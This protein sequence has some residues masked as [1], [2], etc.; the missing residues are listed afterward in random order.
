[1]K[2]AKHIPTKKILKVVELAKIFVDKTVRSYSIPN[3]IVSDRGSLFTS[4]F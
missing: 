4:Y 2:I 3:S 1:M